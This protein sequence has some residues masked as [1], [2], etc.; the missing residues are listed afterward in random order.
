LIYVDGV[1]S[2]AVRKGAMLPE[3]V[4]HPVDG[5]DLYV[6][7]RITPATPTD[8]ELRVGDH[9]I[10]FVADRFGGPLLYARVDLLPSAAGPVVVE[11]ELT[12]PSLFL[13]YA[14]GAAD[15]FAAA[16]ARRVR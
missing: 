5:H 1:F 3:G 7:E 15:R 11:L 4:A 6:E 9:A 13:G 10:A 16:I 12:E 14:L 8:A 2:H